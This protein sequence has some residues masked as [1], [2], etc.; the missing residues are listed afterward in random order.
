MTWEELTSQ[1]T[2]ALPHLAKGEVQEVSLRLNTPL[3]RAWAC[4]DENSRENPFAY[5]A[6]AV[7]APGI[8][9][10]TAEVEPK[11]ITAGRNGKGTYE[12]VGPRGGGSGN[13]CERPLFPRRHR[14]SSKRRALACAALSSGRLTPAGLDL[15][16]T[17]P[18]RT[19]RWK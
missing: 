9:V 17:R 6:K 11:T 19:G 13:G 4:R 8:I 2:T 18:T 5:G 14:A 3:T 1:E 7:L 16:R 10:Y 12:L 15:W